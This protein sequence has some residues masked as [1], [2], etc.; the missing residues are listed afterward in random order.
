MFDYR[1]LR[2]IILLTL[3]PLIGCASLST[4]NEHGAGDFEAPG[5][6]GSEGACIV[7]EGV[8]SDNDGL[9]DIYEDLNRNCL[10]D[11][12]ETDP[13]NPDTDGDGL[14]DGDEDADGNGVWDAD[15]GEL[16]PL[17]KDT[18]GN[19]VPDAE[20]PKAQVCNRA[21][22]DRAIAER[23]IL[24]Q[25]GVL[26][27]HPGIKEAAPFGNTNAVFLS[28]YENESAGIIVDSSF[29]S[30][31]FRE[32]VGT[33]SE[34][35]FGSSEEGYIEL[36]H[37]YE[38]Q[39]RGT[40]EAY[41]RL[42]EH[43]L[44]LDKIIAFLAEYVPE[45]QEP[46]AL[47]D[48]YHPT[49]MNW[50]VQL[51]GEQLD[52]DRTRWAI[53]WKPA[54]TS[55]EW[56]SIVRPRLMGTNAQRTV[57]FVC[58][59][60]EVLSRPRLDVLLLVDADAVGYAGYWL[61][62]LSEMISG[63][64]VRG[65]TTRIHALHMNASGQLTWTPADDAVAAEGYELLIPSI[66]E[67]PFDHLVSN[68]LHELPPAVDDAGEDVLVLVISGRGEFDP[69]TSSEPLP[70]FPEAL[71]NA[72]MVIASPTQEP[73]S[74][75]WRM[76][77]ARAESVQRLVDWGHAR[78]VGNCASFGVDHSDSHKGLITALD[79][80][81]WDDSERAPIPGTLW[82]ADRWLS[83]DGHS[84]QA[85]LHSVAGSRVLLAPDAKE[86]ANSAV[87]FASWFE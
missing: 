81:R 85:D 58:E 30:S 57:R 52:E 16:N 10:V 25:N 82:L 3:W 43:Q 14:L 9:L 54:Q 71:Q 50:D 67:L 28:G 41:L 35:L 39:H 11:E 48:L 32:L 64:S 77:D 59:N 8:D 19:G 80:V 26:Y 36:S 68:A 79:A 42:K 34:G 65:A 61:R 87:S 47:R 37:T 51:L 13:Y 18:D 73:Y 44:S 1:A 69:D 75:P 40:V 22:A 21:H 33:L 49:S 29:G 15:R 5:D 53:A 83:E 55:S 66:G 72:R 23:R 56:F 76:N 6:M 45:L 70:A 84:V 60:I 86:A 20:E 38:N 74:C 2:F 27:V 31:M 17:L 78:H 12:G 46:M 4:D 7:E 24:P 62:T 63:R